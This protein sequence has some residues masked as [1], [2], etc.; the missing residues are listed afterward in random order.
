MDLQGTWLGYGSASKVCTGSTLEDLSF[1]LLMQ[2]AMVS[3]RDL[4]CTEHPL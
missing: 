1:D 3:L 2:L 4:L